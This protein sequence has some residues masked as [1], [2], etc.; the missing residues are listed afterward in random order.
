VEVVAASDC[1]TCRALGP[2][3]WRPQPIDF[4]VDTTPGGAYDRILG[5]LLG[6]AIG[7]AVGHDSRLGKRF[8]SEVPPL[9]G[10]LR[11]AGATQLALFTLESMIRM[12]LRADIKGIG[13]GWQVIGHAYDRWL[14]TQ[15]ATGIERVVER[16]RPYAGQNAWPDGW[17][18]REH[19]LHHRRSRMGATVSWLLAGH[20]VA[21]EAGRPATAPN[22]DNGPGGMLRVGVTGCLLPEDYSLTAGAIIAAHTH[23]SPEGYIPGAALSRLARQLILGEDLQSAVGTTFA[24][25]GQ[26]EGSD[27]TRAA[28]YDRT[29]P[30]PHRGAADALRVGIQAAWHAQDKIHEA[31]IG[32]AREYGTA[33]S[34][35]TGL[36]LGAARGAA[37]FDQAWVQGL[38]TLPIVERIARDTWLGQ[39]RWVQDRERFPYTTDPPWEDGSGTAQ[40]LWSTG[41]PG[42]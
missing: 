11:A 16:W 29:S 14:F 15:R 6:L 27:S 13:P 30:Q 1:A 2:D 5:G 7:D 34:V 19:G 36:L 20:Q 10:S 8:P 31:V 37:A 18:V 38:A 33:G 40:F 32:I 41:F 23:G 21:E 24:A 25:L 22:N 39:E 4:A 12:V 9:P 17:L 26:W 3:D 42:W 35:A 28:L